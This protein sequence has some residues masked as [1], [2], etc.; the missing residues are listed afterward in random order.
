MT[1]NHGHPNGDER[2]P[3]VLFDKS[4]IGARGI[5]I[6]FLVLAIF[7]LPLTSSFSDSM[8]A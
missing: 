1:T 8:S 3:S 2:N 4:D 7:A 6:F 5:L